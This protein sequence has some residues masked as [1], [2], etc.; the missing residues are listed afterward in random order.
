[1]W[2]QLA[3][4]LVRIGTFGDDPQAQPLTPQEERWQPAARLVLTLSPDV[5]TST[6]I[7]PAIDQRVYGPEVHA[8]ELEDEFG[9]SYKHPELHTTQ[10]PWTRHI[11]FEIAEANAMSALGSIG[12]MGYLVGVPLAPVMTVYDFFIK[13]ALDQLYYNLYWGSEFILMGT[14]AGVTLSPEGAQH[15]WKSDIQIPNLITWEPLFALE[16]DWIVSDALRRQVEGNNQGRR[17]VLIRAVTRGM[18][19][20]LLLDHVRRQASSK[21]Q[22]PGPLKPAGASDAWGAATDESTLACLDDDTL[23]ARVREDS[24]AG[25]YKLIDWSGYAG[26]EPGD[27][28]VQVFVMGSVASEAITAAETLL[29]RGVFANLIVVSSPELLTGI[30]AEQND[31]HHLRTT[32]GINGDLH[33]VQGAGSSQAGLISLAGRRIPCVA[34]C[35]GEAGLLDNI[36]SIVGVQQRTLA[37]RRF[38]KCG[39]PDEVFAY[40]G[41]DA[42]S[43]VEACGRVLAETSLEDLVVSPSLLERLGW[44]CFGRWCPGRASQLARPVARVSRPPPSQPLARPL[45]PPFPAVTSPAA[46][47]PIVPLP[48]EPPSSTSPPDDPTPFDPFPVHASRRVYDSSWC[49]LRRDEVVLPNGQLQEYH[50]FEISNAVTVVPITDRGRFVLVGQYRYPHGSTQWE[51]PAG[52]LEEGEEPQRAALREL[53]EETGYTADRLVPLPGFYPTGGI[54]AHYAHAFC[55]LDCRRVDVPRPE[56]SEQ[57]IVRTFERHEIEALLDAGRLRDAFT[58]LPL[59][60]TLRRPEL[61]GSTRRES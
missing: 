41:L 49:G 24:L 14:P 40:Q 47:S 39:R 52:R 20:D 10:D 13:R 55:A 54:S 15:S 30:L 27:N 34:I 31:Y 60:Y 35:D 21:I 17:G 51:A 5:G 59:A 37:V 56:A 4:K 6:N 48:D 29:E 57:L 3:T 8:G 19:Q 9:V 38:S 46:S 42:D 43:I 23:L 58:A 26:Y 7:S 33:A 61:L 22:V 36:G 45:V 25:A 50:V 16:V 44:P 2:G 32:L 1:M 12:K 18:R 28:V 53:R 11:R